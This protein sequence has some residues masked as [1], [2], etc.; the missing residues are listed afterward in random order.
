MH[1]DCSY[2]GVLHLKVNY[3]GL[4]RNQKAS[5][6]FDVA[7]ARYVVDSIKVLLLVHAVPGHFFIMTTRFLHSL[8]L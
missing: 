8:R 6:N 1:W 5:W 7:L 3:P 2:L 4:D